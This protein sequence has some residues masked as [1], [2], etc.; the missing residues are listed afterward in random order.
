MI[1]RKF[2]AKKKMAKTVT[3]RSLERS[4]KVPSRNPTDIG[5]H[6]EESLGICERLE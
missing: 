2:K 3:G 5:N 6:R 4:Y 1:P